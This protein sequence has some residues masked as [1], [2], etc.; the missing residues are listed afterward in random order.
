MIVTLGHP[1][2]AA[3]AATDVARL[4]VDAHAAVV[5]PRRRALDIATDT[6]RSL[7]EPVGLRVSSFNHS[8]RTPSTSANRVLRRSGVH[9]APRSIGATPGSGSNAS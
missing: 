6:T 5:K 4:P 9:P 8:S 7:N 2:K 3:C 1:A